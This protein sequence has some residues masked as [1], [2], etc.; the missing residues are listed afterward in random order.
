MHDDDVLAWIKR[1]NRKGPFYLYHA[2][3][4]ES[5]HPF[6]DGSKKS[7]TLYTLIWND[8]DKTKIGSVHDWM[9]ARYGIGTRAAVIGDRPQD[10]W[11]GD[12]LDE[13]EI[14]AMR[15][16]RDGKSSLPEFNLHHLENVMW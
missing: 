9:Y 2:E 4:W 1:L 7:G 16:V 12:L 8:K 15:L 14:T 13:N 3:P 11:R 5:E 10:L 6:H